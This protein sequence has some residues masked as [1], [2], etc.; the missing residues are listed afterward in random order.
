MHSGPSILSQSR[1][2][3]GEDGTVQGKIMKQK[4]MK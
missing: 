2:W 1:G 3:A 4:A